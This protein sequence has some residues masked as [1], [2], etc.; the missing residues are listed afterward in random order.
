M[1]YTVRYEETSVMYRNIEASS[2]REAMEK[3]D[4]MG[5]NGLIDFTKMEVI[6]TVTSVENEE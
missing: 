5:Q 6:N 4:Q 3:F 1:L 2:E